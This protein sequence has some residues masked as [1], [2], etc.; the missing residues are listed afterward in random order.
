MYEVQDLRVCVL[1]V[2]KKKL[3]KGE[4]GRYV[5]GEWAERLGEGG[6]AQIN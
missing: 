4:R 6:G 1:F 3:S 5:Y 2:K